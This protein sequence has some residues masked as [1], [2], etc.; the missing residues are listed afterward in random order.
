MV[1]VHCQ[2]ELEDSDSFCPACGEPCHSAPQASGGPSGGPA[3]ST[4]ASALGAVSGGAGLFPAPAA[5]ASPPVHSSLP[6]VIGLPRS[7]SCGAG[8]DR[9]GPDRVCTICGQLGIVPERDDF[10]IKLSDTLAVRSNLGLC[11]WHNEDYG[12]I[13]QA[14][15]YGNTV[16]WFV[17]SDGVSSAE[18]PEI[19][20]KAACQ[21]VNEVIAQLLC[22]DPDPQTAIA[23]AIAAA[24]QAVL[25]VP[26]SDQ[27][28]KPKNA[29]KQ[30]PEA[31]IV[32]CI[33]Q[34][35]LATIGWL[36]DSRVYM[37]EKG[38]SGFTA[39]MLTSDHSYV[40][41]VVESGQ[42]LLDQALASPDAHAITKSLG[43]LEPGEVMDPSFTTVK[44]DKAVCLIGCSDGFWNYA[45]PQQDQPPTQ[46]AKLV[47]ACPNDALTL[48][49]SMI[50]FANSGGGQDNLTVAVVLLTKEPCHV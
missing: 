21:A 19:A 25:K 37:V 12:L 29:R 44:L 46:I 2:F 38:H 4:A 27:S 13:A 10:Y 5:S 24:Q 41:A 39:T 22:K 47:Q 34:N 42:M 43:P 26:Y 15:I 30:P 14:E 32:A 3:N 1:C 20:S 33:V 9:L 35:G 11:H 16:T 40:N 23:L 50:A 31:T 36:G 28:H 6:E 45:H 49:N 8:P 18:N 7:C 17:V 48:A